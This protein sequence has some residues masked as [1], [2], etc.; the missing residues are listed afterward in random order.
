MP[1]ISGINDVSWSTV[2]DGLGSRLACM[3]GE[4]HDCFPFQKT[5]CLAQIFKTPFSHRKFKAIHYPN[6]NMHS[7]F[8]LWFLFLL[9]TQFSAC[10]TTPAD[11]QKII[12]NNEGAFE[13]IRHV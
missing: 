2:L 7:K 12:G 1:D 5:E 10:L 4:A 13:S 9:E 11:P 3:C 6:S 8:L